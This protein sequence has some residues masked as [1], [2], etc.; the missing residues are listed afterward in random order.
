[1]NSHGSV[2]LSEINIMLMNRKL[3]LTNLCLGT[4]GLI[5]APNKIYGQEDKPAAYQKDVVKEFVGAGHSKLDRVKELVT[6]FPNLIYS[7]WDWGGGD[8]ETA[9]GA[10]G[11]VGFKDM[12]NYLIDLGARPTLHV[13]TMLGKTELVKPI[14]EAYP[15]LLDSLGPHGF[16][17][18][19]HAE[20][21]GEV[22]SELLSY[23][24]EKGQT[25]KKVSLI[26]Q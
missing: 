7:S 20:K 19:H 6:E 26:R 1:M 9:I 23:F 4:G 24:K 12:V 8:F 17:F 11:H 14:L 21:G 25:A 15:S 18:L 2:S 13:L 22:A 10:G 5:V 16:T 3:F